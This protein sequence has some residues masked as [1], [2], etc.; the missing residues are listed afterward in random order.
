MRVL[1]LV[2]EEQ[3]PMKDIYE[4]MDKA[5]EALQHYYRRDHARFYLI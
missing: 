1:R 2:D 5:K 4:A 3:N